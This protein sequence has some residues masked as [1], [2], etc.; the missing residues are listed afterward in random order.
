M[1]DYSKFDRLI[2]IDYLNSEYARAAYVI[3]CIHKRQDSLK[4]KREDIE[5]LRYEEELIMGDILNVIATD[6]HNS[7]FNLFRGFAPELLRKAWRYSHFK[8][9]NRL[10]EFAEDDSEDKYTRK[11]HE[12][13]YMYCLTIIKQNLLP[14]WCVDDV[15]LLQIM[16]NWY[17]TSYQFT[18]KYKDIEFIVCVPVFQH[19]NKDNYYE[20]LEGYLLRHYEGEHFVDLDFYTLDP[21]E[22]KEKLDVWLKERLGTKDEGENKEVSK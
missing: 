5:S 13:A 3:D 2:G 16:D 19:A 1:L 17:E 18:F 22:F 15:E 12:N 8:N 9:E 4:K 20:L 10:D 14:K 11:D 6:L 21:R 7:A